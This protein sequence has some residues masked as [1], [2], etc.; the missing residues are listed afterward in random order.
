MTTPELI[1]ATAFGAQSMFWLQQDRTMPGEPS[2]GGGGRAAP[3][4]SARAVARLDLTSELLNAAA[5]GRPTARCAAGDSPSGGGGGGGGCAR[6]CA[7][8]AGVHLSP[9][10]PRWASARWAA[11]DMALVAAG[12]CQRQ[13]RRGQSDCVTRLCPSINRIV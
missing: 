5:D 11:G 4:S 12:G 2:G 8:A 7:G 6:P 10:I 9:R 13:Q 1:R 3:I